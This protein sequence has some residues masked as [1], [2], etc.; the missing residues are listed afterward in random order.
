MTD[1]QDV[2]KQ[3]EQLDQ[4][5]LKR[6][7]D[8]LVPRFEPPIDASLTAVEHDCYEV[9]TRL[10]G[11]IQSLPDL[12]KSVTKRKY[13]ERSTMLF[14]TIALGTGEE[15]PRTERIALAV[16]CL[17][18]LA[19]WIDTLREKD[20][21]TARSAVNLLEHMGNLATAI[22]FHYPGYIEARMLHRLV[23]LRVAA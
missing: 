13:K 18:C 14:R 15:L 9:L 19:D 4:K 3:I 17:D 5:A 6:L 23:Q 8:S 12:M 20:H 11:S 21:S 22:D 2:L 16:E 1:L 7:Y 10:L